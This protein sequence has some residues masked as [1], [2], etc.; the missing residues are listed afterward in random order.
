MIDKYLCSVDDTDYKLII[1]HDTKG[2]FWFV[3]RSYMLK[4]GC[5]VNH[6]DSMYDIERE[7]DITLTIQEH[8]N[9]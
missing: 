3:P 4:K 1:Y 8:I 2:D 6:F 9:E 7:F 5:L